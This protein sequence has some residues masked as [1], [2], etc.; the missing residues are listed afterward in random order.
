MLVLL[1]IQEVKIMT[2]ILSNSGDN[3][4]LVLRNIWDKIPDVK[5][6]E[7]GKGI[8]RADVDEAIKNEED[9]LILAGHGYPAGLFGTGDFDDVCIV[10]SKNCPLIKAKR[11]IGIWCHASSFAKS[12]GLK[13]FFSGMFISNSGEASFCASTTEYSDEDIWKYETDFCLELQ[14]LITSKTPMKKWPQAIIKKSDMTNPI[15]KYNM[16]RLR[17]FN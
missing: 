14:K 5:V 12:M 8:T 11:V 17:Y 15:I 6:L 7:V 2:A 16:S 1:S 9:T 3:D 4:T 13:G 10:D